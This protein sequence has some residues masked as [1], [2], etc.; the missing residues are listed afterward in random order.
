MPTARVMAGRDHDANA[1]GDLRPKDERD[2][3]LRARRP[4]L[5]PKSERRG[6]D[7]RGRMDDCGQMSVV[8]VEEVHADCVDESRFGRAQAL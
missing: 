5:F 8:E 2:Q 4:E 6:R 7:R 3:H 1:A